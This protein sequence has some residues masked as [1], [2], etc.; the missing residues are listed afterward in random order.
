MINYLMSKAKVSFNVYISCPI[1]ERIIAPTPHVRPIF[2]TKMFA[3]RF[4]TISTQH[5]AGDMGVS[6]ISNT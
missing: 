6:K 4:G 3:L 1:S 2:R 5:L